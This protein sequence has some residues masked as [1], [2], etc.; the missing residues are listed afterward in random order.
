MTADSGSVNRGSNPRSEAKILKLKLLNIINCDIIV[1]SS[2][3]KYYCL[4]LL[5]I[6]NKLIGK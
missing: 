4:Q 1:N 6:I 5:A 2:H 3:N